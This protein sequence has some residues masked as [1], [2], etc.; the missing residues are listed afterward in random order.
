VPGEIRTHDPQIRNLVVHKMRRGLQG[1]MRGKN[2]Y[3]GFATL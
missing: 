3:Y 1:L 2:N